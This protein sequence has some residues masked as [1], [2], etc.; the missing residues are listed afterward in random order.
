MIGKP[1]EENHVLPSY[2]PRMRGCVASLL[3]LSEPEGL[4]SGLLTQEV[5]AR[6]A[7]RYYCLAHLRVTYL[8]KFLYFICGRS[9]LI[10]N[11]YQIIF[12]Y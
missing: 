12:I 3:L 10:Y 8:L 5:P 7:I 9:L 1:T 2:S 4:M 6:P 11:I